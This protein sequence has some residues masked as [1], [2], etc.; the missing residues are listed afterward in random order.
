M[1]LS[2]YD[3]PSSVK[4]PSLKRSARVPDPDPD[5]DP[6]TRSDTT[7][8]IG[9]LYEEPEPEPKTT[10]FL[11]CPR[12]KMGPRPINPHW[13][14][15]W[16]WSLNTLHETFNILLS[17]FVRTQSVCVFVCVRER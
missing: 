7:A 13:V 12:V 8:I 3:N 9:P 5:P 15:A 17:L 16:L 10:A 11:R 14:I 4:L 1:N 6:I 2:L